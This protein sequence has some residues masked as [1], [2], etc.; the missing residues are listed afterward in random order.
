MHAFTQRII[1]TAAEAAGLP[2]GRVI[3]LSKG[4]NLTIPRPRIELQS[5]PETFIRTGRKLGHRKHETRETRSLKRELYEVK[6]DVSANVLAETSAW[7][8]AFE[9][10]FFA[11]L[12]SGA[13][14][15]QNNWVKIRA[16]KAAF[17]APPEA[18]VGLDAIKV[19]EKAAMLLMISFTWRIA[20]EQAQDMI[21]D[22]NLIPTW[23]NQGETN[24]EENHG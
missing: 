24:G 8:S 23:V 20:A 4:D 6:L 1:T 22:V 21:T 18:R 9:R 11:A 14:D 2:E 16:E 10:A 19:F 7:L 13:N 5:L 12:P 17:S 15:G 3:T